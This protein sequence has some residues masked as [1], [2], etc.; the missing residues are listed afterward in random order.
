M[1][2]FDGPLYEPRV[3]ILSLGSHTV[4]RFYAQLSDSLPGEHHKPAFSVFLPAR[5]LFLF[6]KELYT[7]YLHSIEERTDDV[8]DASIVGVP[9]ELIGQTLQRQTRVSLTIRRVHTLAER[10]AAQVQ[11]AEEHSS[12]SVITAAE[13]PVI[14][15][16]SLL[17]GSV[18]PNGT[19][20][21]G[22]LRVAR[23]IFAA[24]TTSGFFYIRN[25]GIPLEL[26]TR[27]ESLSRQFFALPL[28]RKMKLEMSLGGRAWRGFFPLGAELTSGKPDIKEGLY[29]G[30]ELPDSHP[31]V[32]NHTPLH[33]RNLFPD[34][35]LPEL[36]PTVLEYIERVTALAHS[37]LEAVAL[38]LGLDAQYFRERYFSPDPTVLFRIF[39]YPAH[40]SSALAKADPASW[41]VGEHTDYGEHAQEL[42]AKPGG[43]AADSC[44][45]ACDD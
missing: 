37:I 39:N 33:G 38:G 43:C 1:P 22:R 9:A 15:I 4:M 28:E 36:R 31:L 27:L 21:A 11:P 44:A 23:D 17:D 18:G 2:H 26:Q 35:D 34:E 42:S 24:C 8:L 29:L 32:A 6:S 45:P 3:A 30:T 19:P 13:V 12:S 14:D 25:H 10:K 5:S 41:G 20:S 16:A 7:R 40:A